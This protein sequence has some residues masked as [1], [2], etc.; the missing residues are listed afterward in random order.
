[1]EA[2]QEL[3]RLAPFGEGN[4]P[5]VLL[6]KGA[7]LADAPDWKTRRPFKIFVSVRLIPNGGQTPGQGRATITRP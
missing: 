5:P 3:E 1:M 2:I 4:P 6:V 7:Q